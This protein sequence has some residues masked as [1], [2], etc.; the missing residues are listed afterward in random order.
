[1]PEVDELVLV[2]TA[3]ANLSQAKVRAWNAFAALHENAL[4]KQ[5]EVLVLANALKVLHE[6]RGILREDP[7]VT[8]NI[9]I[10]LVDLR[11]GVFDAITET[12]FALNTAAA[13][14]VSGMSAESRS[15]LKHS[16]EGSIVQAA[17][18]LRRM[19]DAFHTKSP[20]PSQ[21]ETI[22]LL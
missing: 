14:N 9:V 5:P 20:D 8:R 6:I 3:C 10:M 12:I 11:K 15:T 2:D 18:Y 4:H 1:M 13:M 17:D 21:S 7:E 16:V 19:F 22:E